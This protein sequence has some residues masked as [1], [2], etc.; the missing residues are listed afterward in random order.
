MK[1]RKRPWKSRRKPSP[2]NYNTIGHSCAYCS[3]S[4]LSSSTGKNPGKQAQVAPL[5]LVLFG[6]SGIQNVLE[7]QR[8]SFFF[9]SHFMGAHESQSKCLI[10]PTSQTHSHWLF[11][12]ARTSPFPRHS[13]QSI[14]HGSCSIGGPWHLAPRHCLFILSLFLVRVPFPHFTLQ[15]LQSAQFFHVQSLS[16]S[17]HTTG[18]L[19]NFLPCPWASETITNSPRTIKAA[20]FIFIV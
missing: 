5:C 17:P 2:Y 3:Q 1:L 13:S 19:G 15:L 6:S 7:P 20:M 12:Q 10:H 9:K 18:Y 4:P 16:G 8:S 14:K 11:V